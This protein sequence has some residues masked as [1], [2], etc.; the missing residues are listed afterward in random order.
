MEW[1]LVIGVVVVTAIWIV[2]V[3]EVP[4]SRCPDCGRRVDRVPH[5]PR[6][7]YWR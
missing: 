3:R 1:G 5:N 7:R 2:V 4:S 6:C